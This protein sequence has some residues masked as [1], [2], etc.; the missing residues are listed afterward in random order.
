MGRHLGLDD[1]ALLT[2]GPH[3][4]GQGPFVHLSV[5]IAAYLGRVHTKTIG[6]PEVRE[7]GRPPLGGQRRREG[8]GL[9]LSPGLRIPPPPCTEQ[10]QAE[11]DAGGSGCGGCGHSV[12]SALQR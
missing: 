6:E 1:S 12:C 9:T 4:P 8:W 5:M 10:E 2:L 11:R 3:L 7:S